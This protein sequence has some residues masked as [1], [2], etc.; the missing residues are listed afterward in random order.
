MAKI[1]NTSST[2]N[3]VRGSNKNHI[4][5]MPKDKLLRFK[6]SGNIDNPGEYKHR[7]M[8]DVKKVAKNIRALQ[9]YRMYVHK[10]FETKLPS[11][12][13]RSVHYFMT[14]MSRG[15]SDNTK[16]RKFVHTESENNN[17]VDNTTDNTN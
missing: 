10:C 7:S 17:V 6:L 16:D 11:S 3:K 5:T 4:G 1:I 14:P 15:D 8:A 9:S 13:K 2:S 12:L